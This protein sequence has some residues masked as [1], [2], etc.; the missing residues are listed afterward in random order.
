MDPNVA[1]L[2][3]VAN[4]KYI[5]LSFENNWKNNQHQ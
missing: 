4:Q 2:H 3:V 1:A 5:F